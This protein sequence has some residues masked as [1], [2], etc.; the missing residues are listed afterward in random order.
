MRNNAINIK[1][2]KFNEKIKK[3]ET[4]VH[5]NLSSS[6]QYK[7]YRLNT[8]ESFLAIG[9]IHTHR[10][11]RIHLYWYCDFYKIN[12]VLAFL[13]TSLKKGLCFFYSSTFP[14]FSFFLSSFIFM[15]MK[16]RRKG[17]VFVNT[18]QIINQILNFLFSGT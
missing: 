8:R 6:I 2:E 7:I 16:R 4:Q 11:T 9:N 5:W 12:W 3:S 18:L 17:M 15:S 10:C 14:S 13:K 1:W